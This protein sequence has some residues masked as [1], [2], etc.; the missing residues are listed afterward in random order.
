MA[1]NPI[2]TDEVEAL[3]RRFH[4]RHPSWKAKDIQKR[5]SQLLHNKYPELPEKWPGLSAV[6]KVLATIRKREK[7]LSDSSED[8]LWSLSS[9]AKYPIPS[10]ALPTVMAAYKKRLAKNDVLTIREALWMGRLY[11]VIEPKDLVYDW[12]FLYALWEMVSEDKKKPFFDS[13][14]LDMELMEDVYCARET[15]R[16]ITIWEIAETYGAD[17]VKLKDLNLSIEETEEIAKSGKY[18]KEAQNERQHP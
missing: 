6:Q 18:Q 11:G 8:K 15:Q 9:T 16:E 3:I 7:G 1:R 5:V 17:P 12:A 4:L 10:E 14:D 2:I 13:K